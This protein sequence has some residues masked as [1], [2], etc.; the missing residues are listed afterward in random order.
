[1][2]KKLYAF[3]DPFDPH[4]LFFT[5]TPDDEC[6]LCVQMHGNKGNGIKLPAV[7]C[8]DSECIQD[9]DL[10]CKKRIQYP[11]A[12]SLDYQSAMQAVC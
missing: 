1:M 4:S 7:D 3:S 8:T 5:V 11:G 10:R 9:F 6:N 2:L 12:C